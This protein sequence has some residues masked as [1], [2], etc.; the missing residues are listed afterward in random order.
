MLRK[1]QFIKDLKKDD[2]VN[3]V[4]VVKFKKPV[5]Q[6]KNGFKFELRLG[7]SSKEIMLKFWGPSD[8]QV[9]KD[10]FDS[11]KTNSFVH[12]Q[13]R[14]NEWNNNFEIS[15][16]DVAKIKSVS[17]DE[18][19][20]S[21]FIPQSNKDINEMFTEVLSY[22]NTVE[23]ED[24]KNFLDT[25]FT[26][27]SFVDSFKTSPASMYLH[28]GWIGGLLEHTLDVLKICVNVLNSHKSLDRDL[29]IAGAII[30]DIGKIQEF[31]VGS[32]IK[33]SEEGMLLGHISI[34]LEK[35][36][37]MLDKLDIDKT[38]KLKL[39]H[40]ILSHHGNLEYGSPKLPAFPE[41]LLIY[42]ADELDAKLTQM[43]RVKDEANTED[44]YIYTKYFG[45]VYLK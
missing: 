42:Y 23:N 21:D 16:N 20:L 39:K 37:K 22:V 44:N 36:S 26:D 5:E 7:D 14:I 43:N 27:K 19:D 12:V 28:H 29:V 45:N 35:I 13:G 38:I 1:N 4:F 17:K 11:I 18:I 9:V 33:V 15:T 31:E 41:A 24:I 6:Y 40:I 10:L 34:G 32:S 25:L 30:H 2:V 8:E 3:D